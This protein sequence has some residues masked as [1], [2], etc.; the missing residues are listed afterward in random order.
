MKIKKFF[1]LFLAAFGFVLVANNVSTAQESSADTKK[2]AVVDVKKVVNSSKSVKAIK[3]ERNQQ[4]EAVEQFIKDANVQ[5][6]AQKDK[7]KQDELK[8]KLNNDL[9]YMTKTYNQKYINNYSYF[10]LSR[11]LY[12]FFTH[13]RYCSYIY[14]NMYNYNS[15]QYQTGY[16]MILHSKKTFIKKSYHH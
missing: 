12:E 8:K 2:Y 6:A 7:K 14:N 11:N 5:I 9:Q 13:S 15:N 4:N 3:E 10:Y 16:L 1:V